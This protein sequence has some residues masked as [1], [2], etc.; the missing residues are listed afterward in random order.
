M[1]SFSEPRESQEI[2]LANQRLLQGEYNLSL[3]QF[4]P[5][6]LQQEQGN[7]GQEEESGSTSPSKSGDSW[8]NSTPVTP[9]EGNQSEEGVTAAFRNMCGIPQESERPTN[10]DKATKN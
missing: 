8:G 3:S 6:Q 9:T 1:S 5:T 4:N 7:S 10:G 2:Q